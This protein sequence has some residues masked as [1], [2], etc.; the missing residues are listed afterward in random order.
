MKTIKFISALALTMGMVACDNFDL[1]N[2]PGQN[3]P[4]PD[5]YFENSGLV[6]SPNTEAINLIDANANNYDVT[7]ATV[8]ELVNFPDGYELRVD[9]QL[10][11][12]DK[13]SKSAVVTTTVADNKLTVNP[14]ILNGAIQEV[15][16]RKPGTYDVNARFV[17]Y[18]MRGTTLMRL[19]GIDA[20]Y[21][22]EVLNI[23]TL[24]AAKVLEDAY[25]VVP[26]DAAGTPDLSKAVKM[27]NTAGEGVSS[28]DN[29]E[30]A[31][32]LDVPVDSEYRFMVAPQ[33]AITAQD[34]SALMGGNA[35][36][37][38]MSGKLGDYAAAPVPISG[39][40]LL[41]IDVEND[42]YTLNYAFEVLYPFSGSIK[43]EKL[44]LLY[45]DNYIN[46]SGVAAIN[47]QWDIYTQADKQ[48]LRFY[49]DANSEPEI[50]ENLL[51]QSGL[52]ATEGS[53]LRTPV[54]GNTLY[55]V[56]VNLVQKTYKMTAL[57]TISVIGDGNDWKLETATD[58]T[59]A[60]DLRTWTAKD[61]KIGNEFKLCC[62]H[63]WDDDFGG[64]KVEDT[65]GKLVYNINY[66]G[67]DLPC[68]PGTYDITVDFSKKPYVVTLVKK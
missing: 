4:E 11:S 25:Y 53:R 68:T 37:D 20:F 45:T 13:F 61:V 18:A 39:S 29:P 33:S 1:P 9:M 52:L 60:K 56:D 54:R 12:D 38:G 3:F 16:T 64:A 35:S 15:L 41:T 31:L 2:P 32:K 36:D 17:A 66:K 47:S 62:N 6:M 30:F 46:Y 5:G 49:Q 44:M 14:D 7:V 22:P 43:L 21:C 26:C 63:A 51:S 19:G 28:Y 67:S 58:L 65:T 24:D 55:W 23:H 59:P 50:S 42:A 34:A 40:V 27:A 57:K 8:D 10:G 48:G